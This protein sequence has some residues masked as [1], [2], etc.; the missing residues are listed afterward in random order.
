MDSLAVLHLDVRFDVFET[1]GVEGECAYVLEEFI[2]GGEVEEE[3][4]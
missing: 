2:D 1:A 3:T 4:D